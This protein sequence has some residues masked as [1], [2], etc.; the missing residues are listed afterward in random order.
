MGTIRAIEPKIDPASRLIQLRAEVDNPDGKVNPGQF[1]RVRVELPPEDGVIALPQT[2]LTSNL[3]GDSIYVVRVE[4]EGDAA[5]RTVEQVFV[6]A[7][8]RTQG[9][10]EILD[11]VKPG[12]QVVTAGQNRLSGGAARD[13]RQQ[14]QPAAG[15]GG[16][17]NRIAARPCTSASSS[18][19]GP[20]SRRC[21]A[22]SSCCWD[23]RV[24]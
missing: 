11:G 21:S 23:S 3:Y 8:R 9:L 12:E 7:G 22:P 10:V 13:H 5:K 18:S 19:A 16:G 6:K 2:V 4:G 1:L 24:S 15:R 17:G 20:C 14:R